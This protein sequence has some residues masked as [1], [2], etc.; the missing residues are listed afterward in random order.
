MLKVRIN[1]VFLFLVI[2]GFVS[3]VPA[4]LILDVA[5]TNLGQNYNFSPTDQLY[6]RGSAALDVDLEG[7]GF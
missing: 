3:P 2:L 5:T 4:A 6:F 1:Q 7:Q